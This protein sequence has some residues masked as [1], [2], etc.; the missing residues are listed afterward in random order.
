[1]KD[2]T[3]EIR[4]P[5]AQE[6]P[7]EVNTMKDLSDQLKELSKDVNPPNKVWKDGENTQGSG[8]EPNAQPFRPRSTQAPLPENHQPFFPK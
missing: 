7:K 8:L 3:K 5:L 6:A 4:I 1:M 2:I